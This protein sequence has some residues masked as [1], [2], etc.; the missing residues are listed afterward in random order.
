M[1]RGLFWL[2]WAI[3]FWVATQL[4]YY[5]SEYFAEVL[6]RNLIEG[7]V[8]LVMQLLTGVSAVNAFVSMMISA[9]ERLFSKNQRFNPDRHMFTDMN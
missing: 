7:F 3:V 5:A 9:S 6:N 1:R 4:W 2:C 8:D